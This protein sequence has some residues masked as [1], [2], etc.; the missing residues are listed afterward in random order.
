MPR[1]LENFPNAYGNLINSPK[2][3]ESEKFSGYLGNFQNSL[4]F[5][6]FPLM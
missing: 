1:N 3:W 4:A 6:N 5:E 2:A